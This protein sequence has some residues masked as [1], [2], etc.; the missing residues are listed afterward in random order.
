MKRYELINLICEHIGA[1]DYLEIGV[2]CG[3]TLSKVRAPNRLGVDPAADIESAPESVRAGLQ[4]AAM[5][6]CDSDT[7]FAN[8]TERFDVVFVDGLHVYEQAIK[9]V[10]NGFNCLRPGGYVVAH[11]MLP[12]G[13]AEAARTRSTRIWNGDVWKMMFDIHHNHPA[14]NSFVVDDDFGMAVLWVNDP[15]VRFDPVWRRSCVDV[16]FAVFEK[17][18]NRFMKIVRS[19]EKMIRA[20]LAARE[21]WGDS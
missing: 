2:C 19:D 14:I 12:A 18:R 13:K 16:P 7:F 8:N 3:D 6:D 4:G 17:E 15:N 1:Q 10:L 20:C 21:R 5:C 11:D 9:D